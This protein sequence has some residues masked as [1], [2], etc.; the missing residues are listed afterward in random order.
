MIVINKVE[1]LF[2]RHDSII[3]LIV[4][5]SAKALMPTMLVKEYKDKTITHT[6]HGVLM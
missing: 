5:L 1:D 3:I 4:V 2:T 6:V